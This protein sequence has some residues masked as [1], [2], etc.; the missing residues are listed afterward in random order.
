MSTLTNPILPGFHP[1]PS[2]TRVGDSFFIATSTF[3]WFGG[4]ML[5]ESR[6]LAHWRCVG[7]A[8]TR[9]SQLDLRGVPSSSGVWAPTLSH[10]GLQFHLVYTL[11]QGEVG[12]FIDSHNY[13]VSADSIAG[14]WSEPVFLNSVGIDPALLHDDDGRHYLVNTVW[15]FRKEYGGKAWMRIQEI[16][17]PSGRMLGEPRLVTQGSPLPCNEGPRLLKREGWYYLILAEGGTGYGH[18]VTVMR[19]R[20]VW[21]PYEV[22]PIQPDGQMLTARNRP[23]LPL[24]KAG[25]ASFADT[26][27]G[28]WFMAYLCSRPIGDRRCILGRETAI[29]KVIWTD[30]GWLRCAT[31]GTEPL[32]TS[33]GP[34]DIEPQPWP[35]VPTR[36][37]FD[38]TPLSPQVQSLRIPIA[39]DWCSIIER[40]GWLRLT[41]QESPHS[42]HRQSVLGRRITSTQ[43]RASTRLDFSPTSFQ[44]MAGLAAWYD[45]KNFYYLRI[46]HDAKRGRILGLVSRVGGKVSDHF[47]QNIALGEGLRPHLR[48]QLQGVSLQFSWSPDGLDWQDLG[49]ELDATVLSDDFA[50]GFTGAFAVIAAHDMTGG[51][52]PAWFE[53]WECAPGDFSLVG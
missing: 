2:L 50:K 35:S 21:G 30:D 37:E 13:L 9:Q 1:D 43:F 25:H 11:V 38:G 16:E 6:D 32:I 3:E 4:V 36:I 48:F 12:S 23:D 52:K 22:D 47:E 42:L 31:G 7:P 15:E 29:Q 33:E 51:A 10:D 41:G 5:Y 34:S 24:Q 49:P 39:E 19:S 40:P 27:S 20:S 18:G 46:S 17:L 45:T 53:Y 26:P 14:P 44:Q 8:L 28:E